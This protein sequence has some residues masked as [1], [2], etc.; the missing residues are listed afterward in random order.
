METDRPTSSAPRLKPKTADRDELESHLA[1]ALHRAIRRAAPDIYIEGTPEEAE[2][3][4][5]I[6]VDGSFKFRL[7]AKYLLEFLETKRSG[8]RA[9]TTERPS[10]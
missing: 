4:S 8:R 1:G 10:S 6:T 3:W 9:G 2:T 5:P 7:V